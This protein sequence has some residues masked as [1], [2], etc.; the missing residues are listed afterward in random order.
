MVAHY[1]LVGCS[2]R[3]LCGVNS[4]LSRHDNQ[5]LHY[6]DFEGRV[7][8][9]SGCAIAGLINRKGELTS[10][11]TIAE[12]MAVMHE[13]SNGLGAGYA[14]YGIYPDRSDSYAFHL[15]LADE[16]IQQ[17]VEV[18]LSRAFSMESKEE[19][20]VKRIGAYKQAPLVWRYFCSPRCSPWMADGETDAD[21]L[22]LKT[23]MRINRL[24]PRATVMSCGKNMG[25]FK[26]VGYPEE[27]AE[28]FRIDEYQGYS[29]IG[30]GRFP[31]NTPGWWGGAHPFSIGEIAVVHNGELSSYGANKNYLESCSYELSLQTDTEVMAYAVHY[32][33]SQGYSWGL[34]AA[35]FAPPH[36]SDIDRMGDRERE[37][38]TALRRAYG[39]LLMNGPFSIIVAF[40]GGLMALNDR[41]KLRPLIAGT[42]GDFL[43][44]ASE[45]AA[46]RQVCERLDT[47]KPL[48]AGEALIGLVE[49]ESRC[50]V[51]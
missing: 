29:W 17:E 49:E 33:R 37:F 23:T 41:L 25:V 35:I 8:I 5:D 39:G 7:R 22:L 44:M 42:S 43:Y 15:I 4:V 18:I 12:M 19:I 1:G 14:G 26:G 11:H 38:Y 51:A 21:E 31:T 48:E 40:S 13:R 32:L 45:E 27:I 30:H 6:E 2:T 46:I 3:L 34:I 36:W 24:A 9:P 10:G 20:P 50:H 47:L 28:F 16:W